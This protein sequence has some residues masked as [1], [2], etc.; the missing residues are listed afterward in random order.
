MPQ[1]PSRRL[2]LHGATPTISLHWLRASDGPFP[3]QYNSTTAGLLAAIQDRDAWPD[4]SYYKYKSIFLYAPLSS[5]GINLILDYFASGGI[6]EFQSLGG[7]M[8][9]FSNSAVNLR[10]TSQVLIF[11]AVDPS[12]QDNETR[13]LAMLHRTTAL[14]EHLSLLIGQSK[15]KTYIN[16]L[17]TDVPLFCPSWEQAYYGSSALTLACIKQKWDPS[18]AFQNPLQ[19][20][21]L[22]PL[23][24]ATG[25]F[26]TTRQC[27]YIIN[28]TLAGST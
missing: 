19:Y 2:S 28:Q 26:L 22:V 16:F 5:V 23:S 1:P 12:G 21:S 8:K 7:K 9:A 11:K 20:G 27:S 18:V 15:Y 14:V 10:N 17:D 25:F 24:P 3:P 4:R 13:A 6:F